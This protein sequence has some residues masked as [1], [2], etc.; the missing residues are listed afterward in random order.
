MITSNKQLTRVSF[1]TLGCRLNQSETAVI[2]KTFEKDGYTIVDFDQPAD[3]V[4]INTCTVTENG[5]ADTRY[6]VKKINRLNPQANIALVGCQAQIQKEKLT[7]L[8]NV[9]WVVG[10]GRKMDLVSI[11]EEF[12]AVDHPVV[13]TPTISRE[14]FTVP[15]AG[16]DQDHKRAI[17]KIQDGCDFFCTFCEIPYAR[18]RARSRIFDDILMEAKALVS[19]GH[20]ELVITGINVGTYSFQSYSFMDVINALEQ[21]DGLERIR[22][23][24]IEPTTIPFDLIKKMSSRSKLCRYLH[25]PL[26]SGSD[27]VLTAMK[28]K[29]SVAEFSEFIHRVS[30]TVDKV[31]IGTDIIVGFPTETDQDFMKTEELVRDLPLNYFHIFSYSKRHFAKSQYMDESVPAAKIQDRSRVLRELSL[32]KKNIFYQAMVGTRHDVIFE[33]CKGEYYHGITDNFVRVHVKS[34]SNI[35]NQYLRVK[36]DSFDGQDVYGTLDK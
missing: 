33:G 24:S 32:R 36:L 2:E 18:G 5:D 1:H 19:A 12:K 8:S 15:F 10:N 4:V 23:S 13:I 3:I 30:E 7:E 34:S 6:L 20:K 31:C 35:A 14:S 9:R 25:V 21:V 27:A 28:R 26:Q 17:I 11:V 16:F 22:I 29:Y